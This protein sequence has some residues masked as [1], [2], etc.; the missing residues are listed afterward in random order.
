MGLL[1]MDVNMVTVTA[2]V[3][4]TTD[5]YVMGPLTSENTTDTIMDR[6]MENTMDHITDHIKDHI[7]YHIMD[8]TRDFDLDDLNMRNAV[9]EVTDQSVALI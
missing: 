2:T 4:L 6:T 3:I 1:I 7:T 5:H 8:L 9:E